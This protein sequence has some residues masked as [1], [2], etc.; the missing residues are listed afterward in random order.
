M[1]TE[2]KIDYLDL[3]D[4]D[5]KNQTAK[6]LE[7][8]FYSAINRSEYKSVVAEEEE[9]YAEL[10]TEIEIRENITR[11]VSYANELILTANQNKGAEINDELLQKYMYGL[12]PYI[13][14]LSAGIV[15]DVLNLCSFCETRDTLKAKWY[16]SLE[17]FS[18]YIKEQKSGLP[19]IDNTINVSTLTTGMVVKNYKILC[20]LLGQEVK[21]GKSKKLQLEDWKRYFDWE[22]SGQKFIITD[23]YDTP[24]TKE[25]KRKLGNNSIYVKYIEVILL[26]YLSKQQ[27]FAKTFT[28]RNWW[29]MLG[30]VN[31]KYGKRTEKELTCLDYKVTP[32]EVK[33]FYQ[34]CNKKLEEILFSALNSLKSRKLITYEIQTMIVKWNPQKRCDEYFEATD[35][36]KKQI[37]EVERYVLCNVMKYEKMIQVFLRFQQQEYYQQV[38][39]LLYEYY[40][41]DHCFKQIKIIYTPEGV[42]EAYP[43]LEAKLQKELL[44][45]KICE[46]VDE[47][48]KNIFLN[49]QID[50]QQWKDKMASKTRTKDGIIVPRPKRPFMPDHLD[51]ETYLG[52][53]SIL[54]NE[55]I[56]IG[57]K[58]MIF[59]A[60]DFLNSNDDIDT[61]FD[62]T[63]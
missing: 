19:Q 7:R 36:Q 21:D 40:G 63:K 9:T 33:H 2:A 53:Q 32:W 35:N 60:D 25:D 42:R 14:K 11:I 10:P 48:A 51:E 6:V 31:D 30:I 13:D 28:K 8:Y 16:T 29:E 15:A 37:L 1:N 44:N 18:G 56:K 49:W 24:L 20:G 61:L 47:N 39:D 50:Y 12:N 26:Q 54:K 41:W 46:V 59:S 3:I 4:I 38:N 23:I 17:E 27:G 43:E 34:R 55:L 62:F 58:D 45:E 57:H 22:K 5:K 52:A